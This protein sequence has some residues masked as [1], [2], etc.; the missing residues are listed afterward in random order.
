MTYS[1]LLYDLR[2]GIAFVTVNRPDKLNALNDA[3]ITELGSVVDRLGQGGGGRAAMLPR[4]RAVVDRLAQGRA[5]RPA[6]LTG[7]GPKAF[8]AGADIGELAACDPAR[9]EALS[10][11]GSGTFRRLERSEERRVGK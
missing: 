11:K 9:A 6:I 5:V 8:V 1:T 7:A 2:N 4:V 10:R 3:V